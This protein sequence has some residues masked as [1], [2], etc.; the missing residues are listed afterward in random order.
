[1]S[2]RNVLIIGGGVSGL[3]TAYFLGK[4][5]IRSIIVEKSERLGGF[6]RTDRIKGCDLEAGPDSYIASKPAVTESAE[7]LGIKR[8][9]H[10]IERC[11]T[12]HIH[13]APRKAATVPAWHGDDGARQNAAPAYVRPYSAWGPKCAFCAGMFSQP[14]QRTEDVSIQQFITEHFGREVWT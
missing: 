8:P 4:Q 14:N 10:W 7:E 9:D 11:R 2:K 3:A 1:M 12:A 5:G 13:R 6:I